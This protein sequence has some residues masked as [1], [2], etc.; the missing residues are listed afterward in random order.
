MR[1]ALGPAVF[2]G[3]LGVLVAG[4]LPPARGKIPIAPVNVLDE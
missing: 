3:M 1:G 2:A 4:N